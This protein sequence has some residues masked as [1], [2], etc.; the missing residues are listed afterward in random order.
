MA[1]KLV[2]KKEREGERNAYDEMGEKKEPPFNRGKL[3]RDSLSRSNAYPERARGCRKNDSEIRGS[4]RR[5]DS[6]R[7]DE[8]VILRDGYGRDTRS[9]SRVCRVLQSFPSPVTFSRTVTRDVSKRFYYS[10]RR[11]SVSRVIWRI[12]RSR[13]SSS[14]CLSSAARRIESTRTR[15][16]SKG[17]RRR[18]HLLR[19]KRRLRLKIRAQSARPSALSYPRETARASTAL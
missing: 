16:G 4:I 10:E 17:N 19:E 12:F 15:R 1:I 9:R 11:R 5:A 7:N 8:R 6:S 14:I 3:V 13:F 18:W 2:R